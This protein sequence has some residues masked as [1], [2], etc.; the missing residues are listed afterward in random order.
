[1]PRKQ[2]L[3]EVLAPLSGRNAIELSETRFHSDV[4][5]LIEAIAK[6]VKEEPLKAAATASKESPYVNSLGM[7]LVPVP[8]TGVLFS[9]LQTRVKDYKVFVEAKNREWPKPSFQQT[10]EHPAVNVSWADATAFCEW[11]TEQERTAGRISA[12]QIYR[13][14]GDEEWSAAVGLEKESGSTPEKR[15]GKAKGVYPW[16]TNWPP[17]KGA[18][19]YAPSLNVDDYQNT[20]PA[21]TFARTDTGF[22]IWE[23]MF[24][25]GAKIGTMRRR[26][27]VCC[28]GRRGAATF[29]AV[30]SPRIAAAVHPRFAS[31]AMGS[32]VCW[33]WSL[34]PRLAEFWR[35]P[36]WVLIFAF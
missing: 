31:L 29:P 15:G 36:A 17:R 18:G 32:G 5:R 25:S 20:S 6:V 26:K 14:P 1:M 13:L 4:N 10:G 19:N 7:K 2:D 23:A 21:G 16:G 3:P 22:M 28:A 30:C 27:P 8:G 24:G 12:W 35:L 34:R 9:I 11:L 33:W